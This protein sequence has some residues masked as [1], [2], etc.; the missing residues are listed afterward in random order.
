MRRV[1]L[2]LNSGCQGWEQPQGGTECR[3]HMFSGGMLDTQACVLGNDSVSLLLHFE[4][5]ALLPRTL[6]EAAHVMPRPC[7]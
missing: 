3:Q 4:S 7:A 6:S 1:L 2:L 5:L